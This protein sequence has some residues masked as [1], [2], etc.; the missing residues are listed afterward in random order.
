MND[1]DGVDRSQGRRD[2]PQHRYRQLW[3][4]RTL[5]L[6][7]VQHRAP[8]DEAHDQVGSLVL[9]PPEAVR[10]RYVRMVECRHRLGFFLETSARARPDREPGAAP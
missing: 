10:A 8:F 3:Q 4:Q 2:I 5:G 6:E 7:A 1:A 9:E